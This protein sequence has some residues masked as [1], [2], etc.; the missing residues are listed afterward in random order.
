MPL[1]YAYLGMGALSSDKT[2]LKLSPRDSAEWRL[3]FFER[4]GKRREGR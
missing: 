4:M 1:Y 2:G 3:A